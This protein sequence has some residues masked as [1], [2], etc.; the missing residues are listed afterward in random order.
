[1]GIAPCNNRTVGDA[2][3]F[4]LRIHRL[5]LR[6]RWESAVVVAEDEAVKG[7]IDQ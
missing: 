5:L 6:Q 7:T 2:V 1:M 3:K 4:Q